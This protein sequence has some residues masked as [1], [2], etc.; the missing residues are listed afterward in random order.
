MIN[1]KILQ[2]DC[3]SDRGPITDK[4]LMYSI[5]IFFKTYSL[6]FAG[7]ELLAVYQRSYWRVHTTALHM[8]DLYSVTCSSA[9]Y[10]RL[11]VLQSLHATEGSL[12]AT[13]L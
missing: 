11:H 5:I 9:V 4:E 2:Q 3:L 12:V 1:K 10:G 7:E 8:E 6:F 13:A